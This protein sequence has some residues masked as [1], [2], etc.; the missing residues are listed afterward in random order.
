MF[1]SNQ[2]LITKIVL[3]PTQHLTLLTAQIIL[4][5]Q[6]KPTN[7]RIQALINLKRPNKRD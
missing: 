7:K 2:N 1:K 4:T 3:F 6:T 5:V